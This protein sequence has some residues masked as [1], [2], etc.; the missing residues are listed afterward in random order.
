MVSDS[1]TLINLSGKYIIPSFIDAHIHIESTMLSL[2]N[3]AKVAVPRGTGGVV[4]DPHELANVIGLKAL[5]VL[6]NEAEKLPMDIFLVVPSCVPAAPGID[7]A[8]AEIGPD[9]IETGLK[10]EQV[11]GLGEMMNY[12]GVIGGDEEVL[13][14]INRALEMEKIIDGHAPLV[15]GK[16]LQTYSL[17]GIKTDHESTTEREVV[18][19]LRNGMFVMLREGSLSKNLNLVKVVLDNDLPLNRLLMVSDDLHPDEILEEGHMDGKLRKIVELGV[20]PVKAVKMVTLTPSQVYNLKRIGAIAPG[21]KANLVVVNDLKRFRVEMVLYMGEIVAKEG[22]LVRRIPEYKYPNFLLDTFNLK[23][24]PS[25]DDLKIN[26]K[27]SKPKVKVRVIGVI[28]GSLLTKNLTEEVAVKDGQ[29]QID[30]PRDILEV[31]VVERH[32]ASGEIGKGLVRG[33]GLKKGAIASSI[34]HDSHNI[35]AVGTNPIDIAK[36]IKEVYESKGGLVVV[37]NEKVL[38]KLEL[39]IAGLMSLES[40]EKVAKKFKKLREAARELG[41]SLNN[42]FMTLSFLALPVIPELKITTK[43]LFDVNKFKHVNIIVK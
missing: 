11:V 7:T 43:G 19:K 6:I 12:P 20:D 33:F 25:I 30:V 10:F 5:E 14:K 34:A 16:D 9:D 29:I 1:T 27:T 21:Y 41:S 13:A 37:N 3:F 18:E 35:I 24:L 8:G 31:I 38:A 42:P 2:S 39:P 22:R 23:K 28:E 17:P 26:V 32:R 36:A 15:V 40:P 4:A